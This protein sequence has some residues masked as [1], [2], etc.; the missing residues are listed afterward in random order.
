MFSETRATTVVSQAREVLQ[1]VRVDP[2]E[3]DPGLLD[4]VVGLAQGAEH[5]VG[6]GPQPGPVL[7][8]LLRQQLVVVHRSHPVV[9]ACHPP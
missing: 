4:G 6:H 8:E 7:L 9:G 2:A 1:L 3:A 5:P